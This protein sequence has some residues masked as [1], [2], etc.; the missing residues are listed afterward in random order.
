M[1]ES[2]A[3]M[4]VVKPSQPG[5]GGVGMLRE[6]DSVAGNQ[7]WPACLGMAW[8]TAFSPHHLSLLYGQNRVFWAPHLLPL[9][10]WKGGVSASS[11]PQSRPCLSQASG[12]QNQ[13]LGTSGAVLCLAAQLCLTLFIPMDC[14]P[15]G[16][17][18][19]GDSPGKNTRVGGHAL[20]Q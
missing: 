7:P 5:V 17:S 14:S 4:W 20:L 18:V 15:P 10:P 3:E 9:W 13:A 1:N 16:S 2:E 6:G 12:S 8:V 19:H 11:S